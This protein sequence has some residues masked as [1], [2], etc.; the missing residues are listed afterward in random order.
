MEVTVDIRL[1]QFETAG[2][3]SK[4]RSMEWHSDADCS[5]APINRQKTWVLSEIFSF[6][7]SSST[8]YYRS[9]VMELSILRRAGNT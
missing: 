8:S 4:V 6:G 3:S 1:D 7:K 2:E 5:D 9:L